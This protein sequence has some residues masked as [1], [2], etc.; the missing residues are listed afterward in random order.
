MELSDDIEK[1]LLKKLFIKNYSKSI[2]NVFLTNKYNAPR[3]LRESHSY[4][5][6]SHQFVRFLH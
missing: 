2:E 3:L 1:Y 4:S 6:L 5:H